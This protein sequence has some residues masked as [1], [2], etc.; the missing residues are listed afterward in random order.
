MSSFVF[1]PVHSR[2]LGRSLGV[3]LV[4]FKVCNDDCV[5]CQLGRTTDHT[6]ERRAY[7]PVGEVLSQLEAALRGVAAPDHVTLAGSGEPTLH[8]ELSEVIRG[9]R[10][11]T[12]APIAI[13]TNGGLLW[14]A[15]V[16]EDCALADVVI[17]TLSAGSEAVYQRLIRPTPGLTLERVVAGMADFRAM[18]AGQIWLEVFLVQGV[19]T[20]ETELE[21]IRDQVRRLRPDRVQLNTAVRPVPET[22][23]RPLTLAEMNR[24]AAIIGPEAEVI[25]HTPPPPPSADGQVTSEA[26]MK[27]VQCH[28]C[29][30]ADLA[31]GL[32]ASPAMLTEIIEQLVAEGRIVKNSHAGEDFYHAAPTADGV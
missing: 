6:V 4:P 8:A 7:V 11:L 25:S 32:T 10:R 31:Q 12:D 16:R 24:A 3:D 1:G 20:T 26:V 18:F 28:P 29:T 30:S 23:L 13:L 2:R 22:P 21:A 17:P 19:N 14:D 9:A 5:Y 15:S 27:L